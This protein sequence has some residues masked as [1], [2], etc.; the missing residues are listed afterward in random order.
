MNTIQHR[1]QVPSKSSI[2]QANQKYENEAL[3]RRRKGIEK[4]VDQQY[5]EI[6]LN[7]KNINNS[8]KSCTEGMENS[9]LSSYKLLFKK[10]NMWPFVP[11]LKRSEAV[12]AGGR[13]ILLLTLVYFIIFC[14]R[15]LIPSAAQFDKYFF[16]ENIYILLVFIVAINMLYYVFQKGRLYVCIRS[17][18]EKLKEIDRIH[19][20]KEDVYKKEMGQRGFKNFCENN[21]GF[22][23]HMP[24]NREP[25]RSSSFSFSTHPGVNGIMPAK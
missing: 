3:D 7:K 25:L 10:L 2:V 12:N 14:I 11:R 23:E 17:N 9:Y 16:T 18:K 5:P 13:L 21:Y 1:V 24:V 8:I 20:Q 19:R 22:V 15:F 6:A 4:A